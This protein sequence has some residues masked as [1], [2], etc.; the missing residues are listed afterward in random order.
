[1]SD[2]LR[3]DN[4]VAI[5][6]GAGGGIGRGHAMLLA[7]RG[8]KVVVN[9]LG[10]SR[11]GAGSDPAT[12]EGVAEEIRAAGGE[13]IANT[14]DV[15]KPAGADTL[16]DDAVLEYG[17]VDIVVNNAGLAPYLDRPFA[18]TSLE[19]F[20]RQ[21][22][23][24]FGGTYNV[25]RA[26]WPLMVKRGFGRIINTC[27]TSGFYG[28]PY[29]PEYAAAKAA[30]QGLTYSIAHEAKEHGITVNGIGPGGY[31][32]MVWDLIPDEGPETPAKRI[33][34]PDL[35]APTVV[36]LAHE[37]CAVNGAVF[38]SHAGRVARVVTG[39]PHGY[40]NFGLTPEDVRDNVEQFDKTDDLVIPADAMM[41]AGWVMD[42]ALAHEARSGEKAELPV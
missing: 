28:L 40:W 42:E 11:R 20:Q 14:V 1:M 2:E 30:V 6:T 33:L 17:Q 12:A 31:T 16:I 23:V 15:S 37:S 9:D 18:E 29:S 27:S 26:A 39:E 3:L 8:A 7:A 32:R 41:W 22:D 21:I 19:G 34:N 38:E 5:V 25:T 13:A 10:G 36:W 4:R 24:H 35:C